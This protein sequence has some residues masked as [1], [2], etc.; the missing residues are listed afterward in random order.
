MERMGSPACACA[1]HNGVIDL[2]EEQ[3]SDSGSVQCTCNQCGDRQCAIRLTSIGTILSIAWHNAV[4]CEDCAGE[5]VPPLASFLTRASTSPQPSEVLDLARQEEGT[6]T[7]GNEHAS[8]VVLSHQEPPVA[9]GSAMSTATVGLPY[10][11]APSLATADQGS[12]AEV[13]IVEHDNAARAAGS[14]AGQPKRSSPSCSMNKKQR[15]E[16]PR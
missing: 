16:G 3:L 7:E 14:A 11:Q 15:T 4:L 2:P 8:T 13:R 10:L 1:C 9:K 6:T 5:H 12:F